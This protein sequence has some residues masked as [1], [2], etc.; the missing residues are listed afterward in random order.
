MKFL[1]TKEKW[2]RWSLPSKIGYI[3]FILTICS[4]VVFSIFSLITLYFSLYPRSTV[5]YKDI[6]CYSIE[7]INKY[8]LKIDAF[9]YTDPHPQGL[10]VGGID[11]NDSYVDVRVSMRSN[12]VSVSSIE[13]INVVFVPECNIAQVAQLSNVPNVST[14]LGEEASTEISLGY[15][16]SSGTERSVPV[17]PGQP[18][19]SVSLPSCRISCQ[20]LMYGNDLRFVLACHHCDHEI[21][22]NEKTTKTIPGLPPQWIF[23]KGSYMVSQTSL[24]T[25]YYIEVKIPFNG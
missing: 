15:E 12:G 23:L 7:E 22:I 18:H 6:Y 2:N 10:G 9:C 20:K 3:S 25:R 1:I 14:S 5:S 19:V 8:P 11:W 16:D 13:D 21:R 4:F 24:Q 17:I